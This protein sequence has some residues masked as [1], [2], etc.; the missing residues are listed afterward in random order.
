[1]GVSP[2]KHKKTAGP[3][4]AEPPSG[5]RRKRSSQ[6]RPNHRFFASPA[7]LTLAIFLLSFALY[8]NTI[9]HDFVWDDYH[10][11]VRN[12][13]IRTLDAQTVKDAFTKEF[14]PV[15]HREGEY[16][17]PLVTLSYHLDYR[18]AGGKPWG[19][20]LA[21]VT[22]NAIVC[23]LVFIFVRLLFRHTGIGL[24]CALLFAAHPAHT[25]NVA[26]IAGR[27]DL[28]ATF[29]MLVS[30]VC[31]VMFKRRPRV[32]T[33][34]GFL[35]AFLLALLSK[36]SAVCLLPIVALI[37]FGPFQN[38]LTPRRETEGARRPDRIAWITAVGFLAVLASFLALR[39]G[40]IGTFASGHPPISPGLVGRIGLP[41]TVFAGYVIKALFPWNLSGEYDAP[42]PTTLLHP[43]VIAGAALVV[44]LLWSA[45]RFR[46]RAPVLLGAG[47]FIFGLVP[48]LHI[49]PIGEISADRFLYFPSLGVALVLGWVFSSALS[50]ARPGSR[51]PEGQNGGA[52][53]LRM[54][55]SLARGLGFL[56]VIVWVLWAGR[57][58]VRNGDWKNNDVFYT[59]TVAQDPENPRAHVNS[60]NVERDKGDLA[61]AVRA[62]QRALEIDPDYAEALS[63][64]AG[65]YAQQGRYD[66]AIPLMERALRSWSGNPQLHRNLGSLY[67][68]T[69]RY[70]MA[71]KHLSQALSIDADDARAHYSLGLVRLEQ[72]N[73]ASARTH[74]ERAAAGGA[75]LLMSFYHLAVIE[76]E[77][78]NRELA[79]E[80]ARQFLA[81]YAN[82]DELRRTAQAI[83][84]GE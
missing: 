73:L 8:A 25:E 16:F 49:I 3:K 34:A 68:S 12:E 7:G 4:A 75:G 6:S 28:I 54:P 80:Y 53:D 71:E 64:L 23:A 30:L 2:A 77:T 55:L 78:G 43:H 62:Y 1:M 17:R 18:I 84:S 9:G 59:K 38:L 24:A 19:F 61:G 83:A 11:I 72:G 70:D 60:G 36:E 14:I 58:A 65:I 47:I 26:W 39:H 69:R 33:I 35:A 67:L 5:K 20:H 51:I 45:W 15:P 27:T 31:Y 50:H 41:L 44:L 22:V 21:N 66:D 52:G 74:F 32:F 56:F 82:D 63:N 13:A 29:W 76:K 10:T 42:V 40:A 79:M 46:R 37:E 48:V 57:T 81:E